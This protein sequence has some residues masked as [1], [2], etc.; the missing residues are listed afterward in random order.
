MIRNICIHNIL[1]L[2]TVLGL[3]LL[4]GFGDCLAVGTEGPAKALQVPRDILGM[5]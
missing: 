1:N 2:P 4:E 3:R 5:T